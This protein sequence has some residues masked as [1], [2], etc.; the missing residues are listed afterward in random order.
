MSKHGWVL[1]TGGAG[2]VA[3][4]VI[5]E[6]LRHDLDV[7]VLDDLSTGH[8]DALPREARLAV[9]DLRD[10]ALLE[11]LLSDI[12]EDARFQGTFHFAARTEVAQSVGNPLLY[13]TVN[14]CGSATL[15][16]VLAERAPDRPVIFSSSAG[17]YGNPE[18][19]P[20]P[21][22][23]RL[24]PM[25]PYG[26]T[27]RDVEDLLADLHRSVG[28]PYMALRYFNAAGALPGIQERHDPESHLIPNLL[29]AAR[30][31]ESVSLY[32]TDYP[33]P[34]GTA[35]RDYVHIADLAEG[36][37]RALDHLLSGG[38]SAVLNLGSGQGSSIREVLSAA[39]TVVGH[40]IP[41]A[42]GDRRP[43]DPA[44]LVADITRARSL[45][46]FHP[47]R[48]DIRTVLRDAWAYGHPNA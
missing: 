38:E 42:F 40:G 10:R 47:N 6:I 18:T 35:I 33:T 48:S 11:E 29:R 30:T 14:V 44:I 7:I 36:H 3:S 16:A 23:A 15:L 13:Y 17:V 5:R 39:E 21:E 24:T 19:V 31:G 32:G 45:I 12:G 1:V 8:A 41:H 26:E 25:S 46:D 28:L 4:A 34:D 22:T 9:G 27:K 43:G 2:Y 37:V 20:I